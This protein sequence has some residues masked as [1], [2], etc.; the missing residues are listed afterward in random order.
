MNTSNYNK[1]QTTKT[2]T[3]GDVKV[4]VNKFNKIGTKRHFW[5]PEL[6]GQRITRTMFSNLGQAEKFTKA[7]LNQNYA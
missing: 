4:E 2:I 5:T 6:N 1:V 7:W 3:L